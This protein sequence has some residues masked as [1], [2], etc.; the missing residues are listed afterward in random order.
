MTLLASDLSERNEYAIA[1]LACV[2]IAMAGALVFVADVVFDGVAAGVAGV[3][4][5]GACAWCWYLQRLVRR[6]RLFRMPCET[7][8]LDQLG[9][10]S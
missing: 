6:R 7:D 5:G 1:G 2:G 9:R 8:N 4:A 10:V 3:V